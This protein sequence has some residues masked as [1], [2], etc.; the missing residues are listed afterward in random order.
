MSSDADTP[1]VGKPKTS[2]VGI[3]GIAASMHYAMA[4]MGTSR[5][6]RTLRRMN[7]VDGFDCPSCAWPDPDRRKAA[8]FC[9]NGAKA[10]AWEATRKRVGRDFFAAHSIAE[11][12]E[13]PDH[14]LEHN[15]R[16][17]EPMY[18]APDATNYTPIGW[19]EAFTL[20]A[21]RL[22]AMADPNRAVFYTSGRASNEAAFV[23]QL[24]ARRL[25]T[26]NL[27]DCSNMCH[28]SSGAALNQT[29]G[30]GK[31]T[32][33]LNDIAEHAELIVIVGQNPGT[34]HPRMLTALEDA[35]KRGAKI[36]AI[37]PLPEAGLVRFK[38][39]QTPRGL[40]GPG[41]KL[42]DQFLSV[43]VNG[44]LALFAGA[45]KALLERGAIDRDFIDRYGHGFDDVAAHWQALD[46]ADVERMSGLPR[47]EI[48]DFVSTYAASESTIVCWAMGLTQH[49]NA[50]ATIREIVNFLLLRGNIGRP[51]AGAA[52]IRGHSNVQGDRTM[53]IWEKMPDAFLDKLQGEFG[54]DPPREHGVDTVDAI[55]ALRD[56]KVDVFMALGGNFVAATPDSELTA[57]AMANCALTVHVAT[58][59]NR[60]HLH[61][62]REALLLP[63][64]GRTER[65]RQVTGEQFVTVEDSMSMVHPSRGRLAPGSEH[66][67]SEIAIVCGLGHAL[68][69]DDVGWL[70]M[71]DDYRIIRRHIERVVTGFHSFEERV[72]V[73]GGFVLPSGPR[74]SRTFTTST[75]K[76][77]F[78]V[79]PPD[80]VEVPPGHL[81]LQTVRS[82][83]QFNTSVYGLNDRY[84]G[85][86]GGRRVI[87]VNSDD[88]A[89]FGLAD[90]DLV[91][92]VSVWTDGE[93][94]ANAFRAI[95]YPT[96]TGCAA[97]YFP[98]ANVLV[99][100]DSVA[101]T[102]NTPTSKS[103]V[104][105]LE[106]AG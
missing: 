98:E 31:G 73:P 68:F 39:P 97:A 63:C 41:T 103:T 43:R 10:V 28:E 64:L 91:D 4:E 20:T 76:A 95:A 24:L 9:E 44:D 74:D 90:G 29:I 22:R 48:E 11:L 16:L 46:W 85:V 23:Y 86:K 82:H 42:A 18:L 78:T 3:P 71:R 56:G 89:S 53:G 105:R 104:I 92:V 35:K 47:K 94:R 25:G 50:V 60:S 37:N 59:L 36:V 99:P 75:G 13:Q 54:F 106:R 17:T 96:P 83:D 69:G 19:D 52:P 87:F 57:A 77:N 67:R 93:R 2:A 27:P 88:L 14:W 65:D 72:V 6:I 7:H 8:E 62:G 58:K 70:A 15:G 1:K 40:A 84:R 61:H 5:T 34:N 49:R 79:N 51:G 32:V 38:N 26:N 33:T 12:R 55:R 66:L 81:L 102:S 45:N 100:L 101:E 21:E 80:T 30:I